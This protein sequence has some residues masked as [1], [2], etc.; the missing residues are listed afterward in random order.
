MD[1]GN[2]KGEGGEPSPPPQLLQLCLQCGLIERL[3]DVIVRAGC[4]PVVDVL[5]SPF[6]VQNTP[7]SPSSVAGST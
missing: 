1:R 6:E 7:S 2:G 3:D 4:D 5:A